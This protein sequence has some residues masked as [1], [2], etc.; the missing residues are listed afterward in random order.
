MRDSEP[1]DTFG[2][3]MKI[4]RTTAPIIL[5][6]A[7]RL[8][9]TVAFYEQLLG[10]R[11]RGRFRNPSGTLEIVLIGPIMLIGG[12]EE[13]LESRREMKA[14]FIVDSLADC[15]AWL[16]MCGAAVVEE[17]M[18][19]PIG[20]DGPL[21]TFMFVRHPNGE[22]VEYLEVR[23]EAESHASQVVRRPAFEAGGR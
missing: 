13:A 4:L 23:S 11:V 14:T 5:S 8:P 1:P 15:R 9:A 17:P 2:R 3:A 7:K 20:S 18:P 6:P 22:L 12:S 16:E 19:G 10:E 21:G